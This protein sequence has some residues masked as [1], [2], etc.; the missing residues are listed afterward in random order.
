MLRILADENFNERITNGLRSSHEFQLVLASDV[1]LLATPDPII[2]EWAAT[3]DCIVLTHDR[4][5]MPPFAYA[6]IAAGDLMTGLFIVPTLFPVGRAIYELT[7]L[8]QL[9]E[10]QDWRDQ[11]IFFPL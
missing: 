2:L 10:Q 1:G 6:R 9:S 3:N 4:S 11:V 7:F 8:A 5:T